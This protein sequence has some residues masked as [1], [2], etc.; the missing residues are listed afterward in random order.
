[1]ETLFQITNIFSLRPY[2]NSNH[3][4]VDD[5]GVRLTV[6]E[7]LYWAGHDGVPFANPALCTP[8]KVCDTDCGA[9]IYPIGERVG[10]TTTMEDD[11]IIQQLYN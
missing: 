7:W 1:M 9:L 4:L 6:R 10:R 11:Y 3:H 2:L 8:N 5:D